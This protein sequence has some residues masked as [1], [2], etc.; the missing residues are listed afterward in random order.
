MILPTAVSDRSGPLVIGHTQAAMARIWQEPG[1]KQVDWL[2]PPRAGS[3]LM[4]GD[5]VLHHSAYLG[6]DGLSTNARTTRG[7]PSGQVLAQRA[8][9]D[10]Q[11]GFRADHRGFRGHHRL[12]ADRRS[13]RVRQEGNC[14]DYK[15]LPTNPLARYRA[16]VDGRKTVPI[17]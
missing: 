7:P 2:K 12:Q 10:D 3:T 9:R 16:A 11:G 1:V 5:R 15:D 8:G 13:R 17:N 14:K 6:Y 4:I